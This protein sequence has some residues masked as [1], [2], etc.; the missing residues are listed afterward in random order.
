[1]TLFFWG[2][3]SERGGLESAGK[4]SKEAADELLYNHVIFAEVAQ[5]GGGGGGTRHA[6]M[7]E[8]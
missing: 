2:T 4:S 8:L 1:M 7:W 3:D 6:S 5:G